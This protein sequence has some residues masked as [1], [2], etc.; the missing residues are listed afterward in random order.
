MAIT[1]VTFHS[2]LKYRC[3]IIIS[4]LGLL[5]VVPHTHADMI[6]ARITPDVVGHLESIISNGQVSKT[7]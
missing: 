1:K 3:R 5:G 6:P 4:D 7:D 2:E